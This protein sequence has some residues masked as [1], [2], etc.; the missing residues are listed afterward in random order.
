[1]SNERLPEG[2]GDSVPTL[3]AEGLLLIGDVHLADTPPGQRNEGYLDQMLDKIRACLDEADVRTLQPIFLGDLFHL[4]RDNSN[5]MLVELIKIFGKSSRLPWALVGNH[6]K[7]Q[8]RFT[9]DVSL[10][11]L[12]AAGALHVMKEKGPQFRIETPY[13][14]ALICASPDGTSVPKGFDRQAECPDFDE[15]GCPE[16]VLW[17][18]HHNIRFPDFEDKAYGI[19]ELPGIDWLVNGHIHRPQPMVV[20][21]QTRWA[22][23]GNIARLTFTRRTVERVPSASIWRPGVEELEAWTIPHL[24]FDEVFP[25]QELPPED[26]ERTDG[27]AFVRGLEKL[28]WRRTHEG[29]GL[30]E[31]LHDNLDES[32]ESRLIWNLYEEVVNDE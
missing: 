5:R 19:K 30:K 4:P 8:S 31:F 26:A 6:D 20:K 32:P 9:S 23:P 3:I 21:G 28:A 13:G 2:V 15:G 22:N 16:T 29:V 12:E 7:Y 24:P 25:D 14:S 27:S 11:V 17:L 18:T 10:A 1:M